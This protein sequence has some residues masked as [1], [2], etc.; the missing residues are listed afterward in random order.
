MAEEVDRGR[1]TQF[2][3]TVIAL[4]LAAGLLIGLPLWSIWTLN[5]WAGVTSAPEVW[6]P[7][8]AV[9]MSFTSMSVTAVFVFMTFRIDRGV[10]REAQ[11]TAKKIVKQ[12]IEEV[13]AEAGEAVKHAFTNASIKVDQALQDVEQKLGSAKRDIDEIVV[14]VSTAK[15]SIGEN[16]ETSKAEIA[17]VFVT[18]ENRVV[19]AFEGVSR[20][21]RKLRWDL[22][23]MFSP[24]LTADARPAAVELTLTTRSVAPP[25]GLRW[26]YQQRTVNDE[27]GEN[28]MEMQLSEVPKERPAEAPEGR[29]TLGVY[30]VRNLPKPVEY[31]FNCRA[32][33]ES[34]ETVWSN[35]ASAEPRPRPP[36]SS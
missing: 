9:L 3:L 16:L 22:F 31:F 4:L 2:A 29:R 27:Y 25:D 32:T 21:N 11:E 20:L 7:M 24:E 14:Q 17:S 35:E 30:L 1:N 23:V 34:G 13:L 5:Q 8:L 28:W 10:K 15:E 26:S 18:A 19:E 33:N 12:H 36:A 6:A